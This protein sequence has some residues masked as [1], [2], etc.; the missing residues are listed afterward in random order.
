MTNEENTPPRHKPRITAAPKP[1]RV[2]WCDFPQDA[3]LPEFWKTRPVV[4]LSPKAKLFGVVT[5]VP[6]STKSQPDNPL[7]HEFESVLPG[8]GRSWAICSHPT[9]IAVSRLSLV[10]G[11]A[12]AIPQDDFASI[13]QLVRSMIPAPKT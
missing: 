8:G 1:R 6:L 2:Y 4:I 3:H 10:N 11:Q 7:A 9:T 13:L 5:V 12:P